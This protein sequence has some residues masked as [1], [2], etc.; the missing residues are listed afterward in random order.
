MLAGSSPEQDGMTKPVYWL[1]RHLA[2]ALIAG[3]LGAAPALAESAV[4]LAERGDERV[5]IGGTVHLLSLDDYPLPAPFDT[6]Y[7]RADALVFETDMAALADPAVQQQMAALALLPAGTTLRDTVSAAT[8]AELEDYLDGI[9]LDIALFERMRP[10]LLAMTLTL[11]E[12]QRL[13]VGELGVDM[14]Y[15]TRAESE[16]K[17]TG[18]LET[19]E[20]H[21]A[22]LRGL[23]GG[24][25]DEFLRY[26]LADMAELGPQL[27]RLMADWRGGKLDGVDQHVLSPMRESFPGVYTSLIVERNT[28]W[29]PQLEAMA[30]TPPVEF[31]LVGLA[32]LAGPEGLLAMLRERGFEVSRA[33]SAETAAQP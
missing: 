9:G 29:L 6:A 25:E 12:L 17:A 30:A 2:P 1:A 16:G 13:G 3:L 4:W 19:V 21:L 33:G 10:T 26:T 28:L 22:Y 20:A 27:E 5:F 7:D 24:R 18:A 14:Y 32:H 8:F 31:V 23:A 15:Q 11:M